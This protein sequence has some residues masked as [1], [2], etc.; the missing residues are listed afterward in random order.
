M[1]VDGSIGIT[2]EVKFEKV[3]S[4]G[5]QMTSKLEG[6]APADTFTDGTRCGDHKPLMRRHLK[7]L[8]KIRSFFL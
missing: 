8:K 4:S 1:T 5:L 6:T 7:F 2:V 3:D